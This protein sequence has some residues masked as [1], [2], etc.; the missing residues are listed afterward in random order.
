MGSEADGVPSYLQP[1]KE[2]TDL[3]TELN[4]PSGNTTATAGRSNAL[5]NLFPCNFTKILQNLMLEFY[6][7][8]LYSLLQFA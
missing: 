8:T 2:E 6:N 4:F 5:V 3:D 7:F 1:E